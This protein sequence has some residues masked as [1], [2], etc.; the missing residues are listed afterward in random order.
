MDRITELVNLVHRAL[1][2][3]ELI[4]KDAE[5]IF[6]DTVVSKVKYNDGADAVKRSATM[7]FDLVSD[8]PAP[9]VLKVAHAKGGLTE[10]LFGT[11]TVAKDT[12]ASLA[13]ILSVIDCVV[14][15][16]A[17]EDCTTRNVKSISFNAHHHGEWYLSLDVPS[18]FVPNQVAG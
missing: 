15:A 18:G 12:K 3:A 1:L 11:L 6:T 13:K 9:F 2:D 7:Q 16:H 4:D 5:N 10:G 8:D 14:P 17:V